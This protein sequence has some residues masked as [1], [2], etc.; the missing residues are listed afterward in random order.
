L[1][2][3]ER[4][5]KDFEV[6]KKRSVV[7]MRIEEKPENCEKKGV[8]IS[9]TLMLDSGMRAQLYAKDV[10]EEFCRDCYIGQTVQMRYLPGNH[11]SCFQTNQFSS[12]FIQ[13]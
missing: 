2:Y 8:I 3:I 6:E 5:R 4:Y 9:N 11:A 7:Y 10:N 13:R 1:V 12:D